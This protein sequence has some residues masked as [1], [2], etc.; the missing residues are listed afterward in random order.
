MQILG[1][2][3][4]ILLIILEWNHITFI[5]NILLFLIQYST[6]INVQDKIIPTHEFHSLLQKMNNEH[7]IFGDV[8]YRKK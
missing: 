7:L 2:L 4:K 1:F 8:M 3:H 6:N 5:M